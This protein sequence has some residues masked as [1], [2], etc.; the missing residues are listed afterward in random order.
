MLMNDH[1]SLIRHRVAVRDFVAFP[2]FPFGNPDF[3]RN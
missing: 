1:K 2:G 3:L